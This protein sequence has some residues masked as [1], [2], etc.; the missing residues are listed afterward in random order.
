MST[1]KIDKFHLENLIGTHTTESFD[2]SEI[3]IPFSRIFNK[4]K[5]IDIYSGMEK[6][7]FK[8]RDSEYRTILRQ[9]F[10]VF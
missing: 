2:I 3:I 6:I 4:Y 10:I 8:E 5:S 1:G 7:P 9:E